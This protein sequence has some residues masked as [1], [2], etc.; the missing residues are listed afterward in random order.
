MATKKNKK[1]KSIPAQAELTTQQAIPE[2]KLL[3]KDDLAEISNYFQAQTHSKC[4]NNGCW[5]ILQHT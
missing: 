4:N 2:A 1:D 5:R 3:A